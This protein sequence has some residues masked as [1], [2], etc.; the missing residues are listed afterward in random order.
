[1]TTQVK[2]TYRSL[3]PELLYDEVRDLVS[4]RGLEVAQGDIQTYSIPSG[5]TQSR[6]TVPIRTG[7]GRVCGSLH[8]LGDSGGDA[9]MTLEVDEATVGA[10]VVGALQDDIDF[11]LGSYEVKW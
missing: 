8:V 3:N 7:D 5:A 11:M 4:K 2:K 1:M 10:E 6:V 9:R